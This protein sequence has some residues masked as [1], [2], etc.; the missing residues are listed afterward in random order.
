MLNPEKCKCIILPKAYPCD[1]SLQVP[2]VAHLELLGVT[3][4]N[5]L[6]FNKH[7]SKIIKKAGNQLDV[8]GR[9][10]TTL[11]SSSK[12]CLYNSFVMSYFSSCSV[13]CHNCFESDK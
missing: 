11:S 5:S 8:S 13:I 4:D 1:L 2:T 6:N 12:M 7:I 10:K 3:I 9:L